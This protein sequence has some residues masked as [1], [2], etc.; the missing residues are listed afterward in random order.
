MTLTVVDGRTLVPV[1]GV[2]EALGFYVDWDNETRTAILENENY[3]ILIPI[4]S[5]VFTTNG[6]EFSLDVPAQLI[7]GSTMVPIRLPLESVGFVVGWENNSVIISMPIIQ[8]EIVQ[9][10]AD[11]EE[12]S[13]FIRSI[14]QV[15]FDICQNVYVRRGVFWAFLNLHDE[16]NLNRFEPFPY[17]MSATRRAGEVAVFYNPDIQLFALVIDLGGNRDGSRNIS[18]IVLTTRRVREEFFTQNM[19]RFNMTMQYQ[20]E[21]FYWW[22]ND[23][24]AR[25]LPEMAARLEASVPEIINLFGLDYLPERIN[26][27]YWSRPDYDV[28]LRVN[29]WREYRIGLDYYC[30]YARDG[31]FSVVRPTRSRNISDGMIALLIHET[32]HEIQRM[33]GT[34][35]L[36]TPAWLTEGAATYFERPNVLSWDIPLIRN[37]IRNNRIPTLQ[38]LEDSNLF[39]NNVREYSSFG[40]TIVQFIHNTFGFE[41]VVELHRNY[42]IEEV[43]GIS[44]AE[45]QNQWHQYLRNNFR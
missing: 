9:F 1:R 32:V 41:Y 43:F 12:V 28:H 25:W 27:A 19:N 42:D 14:L 36:V 10:L 35:W 44:R 26:V 39:W 37:S 17:R 40:A 6:E 18:S 8:E 34:N 30:G 11:I 13:D 5:Y 33:I 29:S 20:S 7:G 21:N 22:S 15:D 38:Q 16:M 3:L 23:E 24:R 45:F 31:H 2:F 4:D